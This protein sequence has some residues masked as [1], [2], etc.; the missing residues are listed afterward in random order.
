MKVKSVRQTPIFLLSLFFA[1][2]FSYV[3]FAHVSH[4]IDFLK[5]YFLVIFNE[6]VITLKF[7]SL[8]LIILGF[9]FS[10]FLITLATFGPGLTL[11]STI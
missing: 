1:S 10:S 11:E 7:I 6:L 5:N 3:T 8:A 4:C 2:N 9:L